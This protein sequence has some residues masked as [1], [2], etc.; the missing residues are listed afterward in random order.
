VYSHFD[1][2]LWVTPFGLIF[3]VAIMTAWAYARRNALLGRVDASH[4]DLLM[5]VTVIFGVAGGTVVAIFM[6]MD[7][8]VAGEMMNHGIRIRL[9]GMLATGAVAMFIYS[10]L[11]HLSFRRLLDIFA[12]P[13][14]VGLMIHR[15]GCF[16]A[17]CCWGDVATSDS[18]GSFASQVQT[19]P[20]INSLTSGVQYPPGSLPFQQHLALGLIEP[21]ALASLPVVPVQLYEAALLFIIVLALCRFPW[22]N[23]P[24]GTIAVVVTCV[25]ASM[26]FFIEYLRAD[27]HIVIGNLTITQL[28]CVLLLCSIVLLPGMLKR[29]GRKPASS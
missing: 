25:Y 23:Y 20:F 9:F 18:V 21:G 3:I 6:P 17:G 28:Q 12:L 11:T 14:L 22:R 8:M 2:N 24:R 29:P 16:L 15:F 1:S 4:I 13:T 10:R 19:L 5:P 27:G 7:H 26:R